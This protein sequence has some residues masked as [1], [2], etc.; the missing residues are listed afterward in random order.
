MTLAV[1]PPRPYPAAGYKAPD[2]VPAPS[3]REHTGSKVD[4]AVLV[5][6]T[7]SLEM[8]PRLSQNIAQ[9]LCVGEKE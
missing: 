6:K 2:P 4:E 8:S 1:R 5:K 3:R 7:W 9:S